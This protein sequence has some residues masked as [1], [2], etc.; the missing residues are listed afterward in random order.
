MLTSAQRNRS[1][2]PEKQ[3]TMVD[4][5]RVG[6][7]GKEAGG[8]ET[9]QCVPLSSLYVLI[10]EPCVN[11]FI[12][13]TIENTWK[14]SGFDPLHQGSHPEGEGGFWITLGEAVTGQS[15]FS[16]LQNVSLPGAFS[17][18]LA[19]PRESDCWNSNPAVRP[20]TSVSTSLGLSRLS[21][22]VELA[23][24]AVCLPRRGTHRGRF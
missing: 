2:S 17:W 12:I 4:R 20:R 10:L 11:V 6:M 5:E 22:P 16:S 1:I 23:V 3:R 21:C 9:S 13:Q 19:G 8:R 14:E 24:V 18:G 7:G 15:P